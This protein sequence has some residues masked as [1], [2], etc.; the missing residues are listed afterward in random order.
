MSFSCKLRVSCPQKDDPF[1]IFLILRMLVLKGYLRWPELMLLLEIAIAARSTA[2]RLG[3]VLVRS[4]VKVMSSLN[5][6]SFFYN[7]SNEY[8]FEKLAKRSGSLLKSFEAAYLT[9]VASEPRTLR[10]L[11]ES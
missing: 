11:H 4:L 8:S 1:R 6:E 10:D 9:G 5:A 2:H 3:A 7:F